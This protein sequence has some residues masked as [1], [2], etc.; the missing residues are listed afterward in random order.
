MTILKP[1][2]WLDLRTCTNYPAMQIHEIFTDTLVPV[3]TFIEKKNPQS[4]ERGKEAWSFTCGLVAFIALITWGGRGAY[5]WLI[6]HLDDCG[7]LN[8]AN[9]GMIMKRGCTVALSSTSISPVYALGGCHPSPLVS[10]SGGYL[11]VCFQTH[12]FPNENQAFGCRS[13]SLAIC[14]L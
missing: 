3:P 1:H 9:R 2:G 10:P 11:P 5:I 8:L 13:G 7:R 6:Y 12:A 4:S 14:C